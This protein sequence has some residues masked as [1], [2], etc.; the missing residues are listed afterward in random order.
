MFCL[1]KRG[2]GTAFFWNSQTFSLIFFR[3][4]HIFSI[5]A[6]STIILKSYEKIVFLPRGNDGRADPLGTI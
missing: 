6:A 4:L 3:Y 2:K 1:L 5:F